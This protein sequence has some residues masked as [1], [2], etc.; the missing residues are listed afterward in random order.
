MQS[1][2][3]RGMMHPL[4]ARYPILAH[5]KANVAKRGIGIGEYVDS[6]SNIQ[7]QVGT[8]LGYSYQAQLTRTQHT[9]RRCMVGAFRVFK[10]L[11]R[12]SAFGDL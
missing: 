8:T 10:G 2:A 6:R 12:L 9:F 5:S 11:N 1:I 3:G 7:P 4:L